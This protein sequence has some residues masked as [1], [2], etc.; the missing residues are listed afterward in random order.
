MV[1]KDVSKSSMLELTTYEE[2]DENCTLL[3]E[4][5][6]HHQLLLCKL[7]ASPISKDS[8]IESTTTVELSK[9]HNLHVNSKLTSTQMEQLTKLLQKHEKAF[10]WDYGDMKGLS[11]T[12]CTHRVYINEGCLPLCQP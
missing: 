8:M 6:I 4:P 3:K 9:G 2:C 1:E 7:E 5:D 12:L 11:P 10:A